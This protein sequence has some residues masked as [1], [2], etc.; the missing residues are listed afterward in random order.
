MGKRKAP[1][2]VFLGTLVVMIGLSIPNTIALS[3]GFARTHSSRISR[4]G[5][6]H[7]LQP[8]T[9]LSMDIND[10]GTDPGEAPLCDLQ[11]FLMSA[12]IS[13][14]YYFLRHLN[15]HTPIKCPASICAVRPL[16]M[17]DLVDSGGQAKV[18]IQNS[19]CLLNGNIEVR[20][21]KKLFHGDKVS[22]GSTIDFDVS[23]EV[24]KKG[25]IFQPKVK[26]VKPLAKVD[27]D[28]NLEFG[29]R[30]RSEEWRAER[31][32]KKADRKTKNHK[33]K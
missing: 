23:T 28:G 8:R 7:H 12:T 20:R 10:G 15:P 14:Y 3:M 17:C 31:K 11:T 4:I 30:Y 2:S 25:Y 1:S 32:E 21:S 27:A 16:R 18:A 22:F 29:G 5:F 24:K 9:T 6:P 26:K 19:K 33:S 13:T